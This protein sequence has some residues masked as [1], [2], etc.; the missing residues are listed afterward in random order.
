MV[1]TKSAQ[2]VDHQTVV[3]VFAKCYI[4]LLMAACIIPSFTAFATTPTDLVV[5]SWKEQFSNISGQIAERK[6][7]L[8]K[9]FVKGDENILD[10]NSLILDTDRDPTDVVIRRTEAM[11]A[12]LSKT[13]GKADWNS[14]TL[15][16]SALK[17]Q[18]ETHLRALSKTTATSS[19]D[20]TYLSAQALNREVMLANPALD[21]TDLIFNERGIRGPGVEYDGEHMCDQYFGH[22]GRAGGGLFILKNFATSPQKVNIMNGVLVPSGTNK[23]KLMTTGTFLS[24]DLSYDGKTILFAWSSGG[25]DKWVQQNRFNIFKI[26]VDGTGITRLTDGNHDDIHPCWLPSGRIAFITT[27]RGGYGRCHL[28]AVP[29]YTLYSMKSDGSDIICLSYHETNEFHPSVTNSGK[30]VYTRWDYIDRD[31]A[32]AHHIWECFPDGTNPRAYHGNYATPFNTI[33]SVGP[34]SDGRKLRPW[35]EYNPRSIPGSS[36]FIATA[37]PHHGQS[38]GSLVMIDQSIPDDGKMSQVKRITPDA[39]FP[40]AE[41]ANNAYRYGT[42]WALSED[43]YLCNYNS[44]LVL[45]DKSGNKQLLY[46]TT[47]DPNLRPIYPIPL[48]AR[49]SPPSLAT[50]TYQG[51]RH[52]SS[53]PQATIKIMDVYTTDAI[54]KLPAGAKVKQLRIMQVLAKSTPMSNDPR[55]GPTGDTWGGGIAR[56]PLGVVPVEDDGSVHFEAPVGKEIYFQLLDST[57]CAIQSMRSGT[58]VHSGEQMACV[59]CH[60]DKWAAVPPSSKRIALNR[61]PSK[62]TPEFADQ[63]PFGFYR[64]VKPVFDKTCLPCHTKQGKGLQKMD[65]VS[66]VG[67]TTSGF[68]ANTEAKRYGFFFTGSQGC[69]MY[70]HQGSR[71]LPG[72]F[73]ARE[74]RMGK[75]LLNL[76]THQTALKDGT[77]TAADFR[78]VILW[79]DGNSDELGAFNRQADQKLGKRVWPDLDVDTLNPTGVEP[80]LP[81]IAGMHSNNL[82]NAESV[83]AMIRGNFLFVKGITFTDGPC[84]LSLFDYNGRCVVKRSIDGK[85]ANNSFNID[86][87][88]IARGSY[89]VRVSDHKGKTQATKVCY[90]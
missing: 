39:G 81:D 82:A 57:G 90:W 66:I 5:D 3:S 59:G 46:T 75:A 69:T 63:Y 22:N 74:S 80:G 32:A 18:H 43:L 40:E 84:E 4:I 62:I 42:P 9:S 47:S 13:K 54:G 27:R 70:M 50:T 21:F 85:S 2:A 25:S 16:L 51:E 77:I 48:K 20:A 86:M 41:T 12:R 72:R 83:S 44:T 37:G 56:F 29:N 24:P 19:A 67:P 17:Q 34:F 65:Y 23:G 73:G 68:D 7:G 8:G 31:L 1:Y 45:L 64:N 28:R 76:A 33:Q 6:I 53:S 71:T 60:E 26:N 61:P 38:F 55:I 35:A 10:P 87:T 36:K 78:K 15:R 11:V 88:K 30:I 79:L 49:M 58:Y 89:M 52:T 14:I